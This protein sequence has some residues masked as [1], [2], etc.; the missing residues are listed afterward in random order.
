MKSKNGLKNWTQKRNKKLT[1]GLRKKSSLETWNEK[2][3]WRN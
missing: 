2:R 3:N 1:N